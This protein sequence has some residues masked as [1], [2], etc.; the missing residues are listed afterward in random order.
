M[1]NKHLFILCSFALGFSVAAII[2]NAIIGDIPFVIVTGFFAGFNLLC[3]VAI[4]E[5]I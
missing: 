4:S 2:F 1:T 3:V 5:H